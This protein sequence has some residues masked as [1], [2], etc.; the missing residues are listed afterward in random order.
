MSKI[1][2]IINQ[3][4]GVGK[5]TTAINLGACLS[6]RGLR[7]LLI[8][9]DPQAGATVGLGVNRG[10][11]FKSIYDVLSGD[12]GLSQILRSTSIENLHLAPASID[13][14]GA[15]V[16]LVSMAD[17]EM[18]LK[19]AV[20]PV[21]ERYDYLFLDAPPSLGLLTINCLACAD[22]ALIPLQCEYYAL[23]ALGRLMNTIRLVQRSL[24][25][26]LEIL[27]VLLTMH[28]ARTRLS[29]EVAD[30]V[31]QR[32]PQR[33]FNTIIPR[34]VRLSEAPS[35]GEPIAMYAPRSKGARAYSDLAEEV[36]Q[37]GEEEKGI[38]IPDSG[39]G[40]EA[41]PGGS[42]PSSG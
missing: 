37:I 18:K 13:L 42:E 2:T 30:H 3:K 12:V 25:P 19:A 9:M 26:R 22:Q 28:D 31:R 4:G 5:T 21:T 39:G 29:R 41:A 33:V 8:D 24:N 7:I 6:L 40:L 17:R 34:T 16:E 11:S 15:E 1:I 20:D 35:Y 23:E 36:M 27:G 32:L 38:G 14:A 10:E